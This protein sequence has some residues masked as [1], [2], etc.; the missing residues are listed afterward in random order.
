MTHH[1]RS[2]RGDL[3]GRVYQP[4]AIQVAPT[5]IDRGV[6]LGDTYYCD[7]W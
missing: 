4:L 1:T 3:T 2:V 7:T 5:S 6:V